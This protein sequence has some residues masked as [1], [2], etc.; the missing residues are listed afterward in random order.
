MVDSGLKA[1]E[2]VSFSRNLQS[3]TRRDTARLEACLAA[4]QHDLA[5]LYKS[6][7]TRKCQYINAVAFSL[8]PPQ[9]CPRSPLAVVDIV[10]NR[11]NPGVTKQPVNQASD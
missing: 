2:L 1:K 6:I 7:N 4:Y 11:K 10:K 3:N 8:L 5:Q 9:C